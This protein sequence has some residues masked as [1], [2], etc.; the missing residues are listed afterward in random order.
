MFNMTG[1]LS[2]SVQMSFQ[3]VMRSYL[4]RVIN[5]VHRSGYRNVAK[6]AKVCNEGLGSPTLTVVHVCC[7]YAMLTNGVGVILDTP[8]A[9]LTMPIISIS[10]GFSWGLGSNGSC[11]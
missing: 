10:F 11:G 9:N 4:F 3:F 7:S 6:P 5:A 1:C 2:N 8:I